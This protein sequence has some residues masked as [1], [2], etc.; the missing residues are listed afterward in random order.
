VKPRMASASANTDAR[1]SGLKWMG[2]GAERQCGRALRRPRS[3]RH[4]APPAARGPARAEPHRPCPQRSTHR[5][6][7][8]VQDWVSRSRLCWTRPLAL[9]CN[10]ESRR[11][12]GSPPGRQLCCPLLPLPPRLP[13][14]WHPRAP[15]QQLLAT[16]VRGAPP[17]PGCS[18]N[19]ASADGARRRRD[20][21][22]PLRRR[23]PI[24]RGAP[25]FFTAISGLYGDPPNKRA[26][27]GE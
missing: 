6:V 14:L 17:R 20:P 19:L 9:D 7:F 8:E 12:G 16:A 1:Q 11:T 15:T 27:M 24:D 3:A 18:E 13:R 23:G 25:S 21:A 26:A 10:P 22:A 2:G 4:A 5:R